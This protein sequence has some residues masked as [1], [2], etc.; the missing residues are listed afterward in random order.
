MPNPNGAKGSAHELAVRRFLEIFFGRDVRRPRAEGLKDVGDI[1]L[2][3]FILQAKN[4]ADTTSALNVGVRDAEAQAV[5]AQE[6]YGVAVIKKRGSNVSEARVAMTLRTFRDVVFRLLSAEALLR[7]HA[8]DAY[9]TH[10]ANLKDK[11]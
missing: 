7:R 5:H 6:D 9:D 3:P 11:D 1:H 4:W 8:P 10:L 2:S